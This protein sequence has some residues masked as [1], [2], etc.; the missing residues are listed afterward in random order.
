MPVGDQ[1]TL[2]AT[3]G[4]AATLVGAEQ[5]APISDPA[6]GSRI[7]RFRVERLLGRGGMGVVVEA[8]DPDLDRRVAVKLLRVRDRATTTGSEA[9]ERLIREARAMARLV[10]P[11]VI[12]VH[13]VGTV[14]GRPFVAMELARGGTLRH[15]LGAATRTWREIRDRLVDAGRG[16]AA[17]HA[18]GLVHRDFKPDNVLLVADGTIKVADFGLVG[19]GA[20]AE[21]SASVSGTLDSGI[22]TLT[23]EGAVMGTPAYMAP[24]QLRGQRATAASD[25]FAFCVTLWEALHGARPFPADSVE[26]LVD[27]I[28]TAR[29]RRIRDDVPVWLDLVLRRGLAARASQRWP[30]MDA[31]IV[32]LRD[33]PDER[34][35]RRRRTG[36]AVAGAGALLGITAG[37]L[38][39]ATR[40]HDDAV[41][42]CAADPARFTPAWAPARAEAL[43]AAFAASQRPYQAA[44]ATRV[45]ASLDAYRDA[46]LQTRVDT[47]TATQVRHE[48]SPALLDRR[49]HCLDLRLA[50]AAA[51][52]DVLVKPGDPTIVDRAVDAVRGLASP[53]SCAT[54]ALDEVPLPD[55]AAARAAIE[56]LSG[57]VEGIKAL[58]LAGQVTPALAAAAAL[59]PDVEATAYPPLRASLLLAIGTLQDT[60]GAYADAALTLDAA[61]GA[62]AEA[63][64]PT[65]EAEVWTRLLLVVAIRQHRLGDADLILRAATSALTRAG[66]PEAARADLQRM[67][68]LVES[69][70]GNHPRAIE[71]VDQALAL[72]ERALGHDDVLLYRYLQSTASVRI[73]AG[74]PADAMAPLQRAME[75]I[76]QAKGPDHPDLAV[77]LNALGQI[78][79]GAGDYDSAEASFRRG[80]AIN[81]AAFGADSAPTIPQLGN[82]ATLAAIQNRFD[83]ARALLERVVAT[84]ERLQGPEA[85]TLA[86]ALNN[87]GNVLNE[88]DHPAEAIPYYQRAVALREKLYGPDHAD[89]GWNLSSLGNAL[90]TTGD[91][92]G[93]RAAQDRALRI[94][95]ATFGTDHAY[96]AYALDE[97][98][99]IELAEHHAAAALRIAERSLAARTAGPSEP[100]ETAVTRFLMAKAVWD[101]GR[102]RPRA[103]RLARHS[104]DE[105]IAIGDTDV[106]AIDEWLVEVG[107]PPR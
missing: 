23:A 83:Q 55:D 47:C 97:L 69:A 91:L 9:H 38:L 66:D 101:V 58:G 88:S 11:H 52:V 42:P 35:R 82:L 50:S 40:R 13:D 53:A 106:E 99:Q 43:R 78:Q 48:Q 57:E 87:L 102:D 49:M 31:L 17:A 51:L 61:A 45:A 1:S 104:R 79:R 62:A 63:R 19:A 64:D 95:E 30:S 93:A 5:D 36:L 15:W 60:A 90:R 92:V 81:E 98:I 32:A 12:T 33:D 20:G 103:L 16:L 70:R 65:R 3:P 100:R 73:E 39:L 14:D 72:A 27:V 26:E 34:R 59:R 44:T 7:G 74:Q 71:L 24:E 25:Q 46:W 29:P 54:A 84:I 2:A 18:L 41:A 85:P 10:H 4:D 107:A 8:H 68:G 80:L 77:V 28:A 89:V 21:P 6:P 75:L 22:S 37:A 96:V 86:P 105:L 56:R 94:F 76:E 67:H